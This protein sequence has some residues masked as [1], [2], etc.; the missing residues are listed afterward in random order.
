MIFA[1][2]N[3]VCV[4][5]YVAG[6]YDVIVVGAGHA[7]CEA[8]LASARMG[9]KT[10][11]V[12]INMDNIAMMPCNPAVGGPAKGQL[13]REI[14]ALG[15][16]MGLNTDRAAIQMR[17]LNTSKGPAVHALRAQADKSAYQSIM[18]SAL[19]K[20]E[21]LY[22]K[23]VMVDSIKVVDN[24]VTG[25]ISSTGLYFQAPVVILAT[26]TYLKGRI[27]IGKTTF[28]GG[29]NGNYPSLHLSENLLS[30][31]VKLR[32]FKT[33]TPARLDRRSIDFSKMIIQ[34]GDSQISNFSFVSEI[35]ERDQVPCWLTYTNK[36][37]HRIIRENLHRSPLYSGIIEGTGPRYCPSIEDKVVRFSDKEGH[38]VFI[39]P[40]GKS[41]TE[42]Y[43]QG[44]STSLPEDV[45]L[46][47]L[48]TIAGL[49]KAEIMRPGYAIEYDCIDPTQLKLSLEF[50][51][52]KGLFCSGQVNGT[53]GYEEAGAQGIIAGI[54]AALS[55]MGKDP[56][57]LS[58]SEA[59]IGVLID[60][61]VTKGTTE[62]YRMLT[63]RAE[64]RLLL[65][66]DNADM[67]LTEK[68]Y[69]VGIITNKRHTS[70]QEKKKAVEAEI[71]RLK[72][73]YIP[74]TQEIKTIL[75]EKGSEINQSVSMAVLLCRPELTYADLLDLPLENPDLPEKVRAEAEIE[76]K[77]EGY[78]KKQKNQVE[79][80][81]RLENKK[82]PPEIDYE[83]MRG[84]ATEA[85][86]KMA[87]MK[88]E[89]VGQAAR[90]T[91]VNPADIAVLL[92]YLEQKSRLRDKEKKGKSQQ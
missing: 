8:G 58:R 57:V 15:G 52:I 40:E 28:P 12:T 87:A 29:P 53:S 71:K 43:V 39:E 54:N 61:L 76:V 19:E 73:T 48:R 5:E 25:I 7:G 6:K 59:Y 35:K 83:S 34:P 80:F 38:Q 20:Q 49:E 78:I 41:T 63:S 92:I 14:D 21:N 66:H 82:I 9:C 11:V 56:L 65:R 47:M 89:S 51:D 68:G 31:G 46:S 13:V 62:P 74:V 91:G 4:V 27:I 26:G 55:I 44:M 2:A 69:Q 33:G 10:L 75:K 22:L 70:Y 23:Q 36:E 3:E 90:I 72:N 86:Q 37:T 77:Y 18:K 45:Q 67:R 50:K 81:E 16:E 60:D 17:M 85:A 1:L 84:L 30:I 79:R 24:C 42:M 64:Y 88:P 32:R